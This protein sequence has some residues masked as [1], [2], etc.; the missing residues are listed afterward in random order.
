MARSEGAVDRGQ[1]GGAAIATGRDGSGS[2]DQRED[3][4]DRI[5]SDYA[6]VDI[7][8]D[9]EVAG[10]VVAEPRGNVE[11]GAGGGSADAGTT[12][13]A[14]S[15]NGSDQTGAGEECEIG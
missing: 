5:D 6:I 8:G 1:G 3:A 2:G 10:G 14:G 13:G 9:V 11:L 15:G 4:R 12:A 7:I